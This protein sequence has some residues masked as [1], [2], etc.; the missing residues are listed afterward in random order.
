MN[1]FQ[2]QSFLFI[3]ADLQVPGWD[4]GKLYTWSLVCIYPVSHRCATDFPVCFIKGHLGSQTLGHWWLDSDGDYFCGEPVCLLEP[5]GDVNSRN[6][7]EH[8]C[9][10]QCLNLPQYKSLSFQKLGG[11]V[12][13]FYA[14]QVDSLTVMMSKT[15]I[16][17]L[18]QFPADR[19]R[20]STRPILHVRCMTEKDGESDREPDSGA[21]CY[22][23]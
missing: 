23:N 21:V 17:M 15:T 14:Q 3:Y 4:L 12:T 10:L 7:L 13:F 18:F 19:P 9:V 16:K 22:L 5:G 8:I 1:F 11:R 2:P 6:I 20:Y